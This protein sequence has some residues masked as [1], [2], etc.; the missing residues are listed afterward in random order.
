VSTAGLTTVGLSSPQEIVAQTSAMPKSERSAEAAQQFEAML[1]ENLFRVMRKTVEPSGLFGNTGNA[2]ST[3]EYL[4]DQAVTSNAMTAGK[5]MGLAAKL[6]ASWE[7]SQ[8]K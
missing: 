2:R 4:L 7:P 8:I 6:E 1:M 3:Y 5:S